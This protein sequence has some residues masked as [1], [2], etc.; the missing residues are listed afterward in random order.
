MNMDFGKSVANWDHP[1]LPQHP[2]HREGSS[3]A[4]ASTAAQSALVLTSLN[5]VQSPENLEPEN[6]QACS[7]GLLRLELS[8]AR[9]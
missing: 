5:W 6:A 8:L 4:G 3:G 1:T 7:P 9:S 2:G